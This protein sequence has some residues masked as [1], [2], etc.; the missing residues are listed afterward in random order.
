[1]NKKTFS[2]IIL[3]I[4]TVLLCKG[5]NE[6]NNMAV[7]DS[8][9]YGYT[10]QDTAGQ[11][12]TLDMYKGKVLFVDFWFTGCGACISYYNQI[13]KHAEEHYEQDD[14]VVF[15]SISVDKDKAKW[16]NSVNEGYQYNKKGDRFRQTNKNGINLRC[17][18]GSEHDFIKYFGIRGYPHPMLFDRNGKLFNRSKKNLRTDGLNSLLSYI[19]IAREKSG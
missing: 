18:E 4:A 7:A 5:D 6:R 9:I 11:L 2:I 19:E 15:I 3:S 13:V 1:M 16:L 10:F 17:P 12:V 8:T 14:D